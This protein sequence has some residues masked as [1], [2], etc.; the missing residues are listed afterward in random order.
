MARRGVRFKDN[1]WHYRIDCGKIGGK[2][3][4]IE[5]CGFKTEDEAWEARVAALAELKGT[6]V[7]PI[8]KRMTFS[9]VYDKFISD[10][11]STTRADNTIKK[12]RSYFK[13][14]CRDRFG[15][16]KI[17]DITAEQLEE[18]IRIWTGLYAYDTVDGMYRF[19][20]GLFAFAQK[21]AYIKN[22]PMKDIRGPKRPRGRDE[23]RYLTRSELDK[24]KEA[25]KGSSQE[26]AFMLG[27][28]LGVRISECYALRWSDIDWDAQTIKINKQLLD[29]NG[30]WVLSE[31]KTRA[32]YRSIQFGEVLKDYLLRYR[33]EKRQAYEKIPEYRRVESNQILDARKKNDPTILEVTDFIIVKNNGERYSPSNVKSLSDRAKKC[34]INFHF[35]SLRHTHATYLATRFNPKYLMERL[36]H[37]KVETTLRYY[38]HVP[39]EIQAQIAKTTDELFGG[40]GGTSRTG[41]S[42]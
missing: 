12:Y 6:G 10:E 14:H 32:G 4:Q 5:V 22:N 21:R 1:S 26:I 29:P 9:Q 13:N 16:W 8:Q 25:F 35:H 30:R 37:S 23:V 34:G 3:K 41:E 28:H 20:Y 40:L 17:S 33:N 36:G 24:L 19:L 31:L 15:P 18:A 38:I 42:A 7:V 27:L 11:C 39:S 2:R